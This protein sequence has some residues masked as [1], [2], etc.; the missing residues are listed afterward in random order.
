MVSKHKAFEVYF[1]KEK[2]RKFRSKQFS[3]PHIDTK[4]R[5]AP[6]E[7]SLIWDN[8]LVSIR[9]NYKQIWLIESASLKVLTK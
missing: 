5:A 3:D 1:T 9:G 6:I 2:E 7:E 8:E 4:S